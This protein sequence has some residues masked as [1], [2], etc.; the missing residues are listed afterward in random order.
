[1]CVVSNAGRE[2]LG[3]RRLIARYLI[4]TIFVQTSVWSGTWL[5][6]R[7]FGRQL[8]VHQRVRNWSGILS[9][10]RS[11]RM[12]STMCDEFGHCS[13]PLCSNIPLAAHVAISACTRI[14]FARQKR[15]EAPPSSRH[16]M[17]YE[18]IVGALKVERSM[19]F[20]AGVGFPRVACDTGRAL[21]PRCGSEDL[22]PAPAQ[23]DPGCMIAYD[24]RGPHLRTREY[25]V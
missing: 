10:R 1:M 7:K 5:A 12:S 23:Q 21:A 15:P 24:I 6:T 18:G 20:S 11:W 16:T 8:N 25:G 14:S 13:D 2:H 4:L 19:G 3:A 22:G 17:Q 9:P